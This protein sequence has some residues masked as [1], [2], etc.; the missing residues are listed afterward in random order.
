MKNILIINLTVLLGMA[1][2]TVNRGHISTSESVECQRLE[3]LF[4]N[5]REQNI[6]TVVFF[7]EDCNEP[8][9]EVAF[10]EFQETVLYL[11]GCCVCKPHPLAKEWLECNR[12]E[13]IWEH[14]EKENVQRIA[15]YE[16]VMDEDTIRP[17]DWNGLCAE[18]ADPKMISETIR[19]LC[20]AMKSEKNKF[21]NEGIVLGHYDR[22]QITT[23]K[24]RF[25]IPIGCGCHRRKAICGIGWKSYELQEWLKKW[26]L[27]KTK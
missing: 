18:I 12:L 26:R 7:G 9:D 5:L 22:M 17:E 10:E 25:I 14:L 8:I 27:P 21:A 4:N 23:D 15:F 19:L 16:N 20:K 24:N 1:G 13:C 6:Q 3:G 2:C 11:A